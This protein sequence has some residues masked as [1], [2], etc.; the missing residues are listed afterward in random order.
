VRPLVDFRGSPV[1]S[2]KFSARIIFVS[3]DYKG[4]G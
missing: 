3:R 4:A 2:V 1:I